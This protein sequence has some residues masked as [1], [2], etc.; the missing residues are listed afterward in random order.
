VKVRLRIDSVSLEGLPLGPHQEPALRAALQAE[1]A[2]CFSR[3]EVFGPS[4]TRRLAALAP[5]LGAG[6]DQLGGQI[7]RAIHGSV[8]R[9]AE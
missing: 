9:N 4:D 6:A 7:G 3:E 5:E 8:P 1:L 2:A